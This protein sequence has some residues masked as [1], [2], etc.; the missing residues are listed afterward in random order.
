MLMKLYHAILWHDG[1]WTVKPKAKESVE[2]LFTKRELEEDDE[3]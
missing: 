2:T 1:A 3:S